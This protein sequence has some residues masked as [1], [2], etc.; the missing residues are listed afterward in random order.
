MF[1]HKGKVFD[2]PCI[3]YDEVTQLPET[4]ILLASNAHSRVQAAIIPLGASEVWAVQYHPEYDLRQVSD[5]F[6]IYADDMIGPDFFVSRA[7]LDAYCAKLR[8][9]AQNP[10]DAGAAWQLGI[11]GDVLDETRRRG[12]IIS[13][14]ETQVLGKA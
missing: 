7:E 2:A 5:I 14:I 8:A 1:A 13:W 3:H 4:A 11:D 6:T 12:E 10:Q 9:L